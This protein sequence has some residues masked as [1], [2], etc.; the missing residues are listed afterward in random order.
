MKKD[1]DSTIKNWLLEMVESEIEQTEGSISN[2]R[3]FQKGC[4]TDDEIETA[5]RN[6]SRL[7]DYLIALED[8]KSYIFS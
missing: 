1:Y 2:E 4:D 7:E 6:I 3:A 8:M 5:E